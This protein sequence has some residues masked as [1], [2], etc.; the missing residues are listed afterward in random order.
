MTVERSNVVALRPVVEAAPAPRQRRAR[1]TRENVDASIRSAARRLFADR[2]YAATTRE[3]ADLAD[4]SET[5]LFRYY[6]DKAQLFD[7][8]IVAPFNQVIRE[9]T[10]LQQSVGG[11]DPHDLSVLV[12]DLLT[13]NRDLLSALVAG[14]SQTLAGGGTGPDL[15]PFFDAG[16]AQLKADYAAVGRTPD[17]DIDAAIRLSFGMV[18]GVVLMREWLF[19]TGGG[20]REHVIETIDAIVLRGLRAPVSS[21]PV[22]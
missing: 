12:Y 6:G 11:A 8:V 5:L 15:E 21:D 22:D 19:P 17:L 14:R 4:V 1:R 10:A 3:I 9:F 7:A 2:G 18:A 13:E 16:L 20:E